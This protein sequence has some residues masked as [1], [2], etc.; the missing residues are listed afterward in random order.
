LFELRRRGSITELLFLFECTTEEPTQL[1]PIADRLGLTV[2]A[3]SHVFRQLQGRRL[4][5]VRDGRYRAT[6]TGVQW[7]HAALGFVR[8][9]VEGR[10]ER[11]NVVS[12]CRALALVD[13]AEGQPATLE[14]R[15]GLLSARAGGDGASRGRVRIGGRKGD[16]VEVDRLEGIVPIVRGRV[17][18]LTV[19]A[20]RL[21]DR[22]VPAQLRRA[23]SD[24]GTSLL[25][26]QGLETFHL[27]GRVT[28]RPVIR[29]AVA[30]ACREASLVG[31]ASTV[32]V[33]DDELPRLLQQF[34]GT[35]PPPIDVTPIG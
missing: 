3:A 24:A 4:A 2:Q 27:L 35:D 25:G 13:L 31:V 7:L 29:F 18:V 33:L 20:R 19:P 28:D 8:E 21:R 10:L 34:G 14:L 11:L 26:A 5:E 32:V 6:I 9:D 17:R 23:I 15:D 30:S 12:R 1:R 16:I 22:T